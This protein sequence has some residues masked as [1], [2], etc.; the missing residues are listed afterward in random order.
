MYLADDHSRI[1]LKKG[2]TD[3]IN[4]SLIKVPESNR[5]YILSQVITELRPTSQ[6]VDLFTRVLKN[7]SSHVITELIVEQISWAIFQGGGLWS[8]T[9]VSIY[10]NVR[11]GL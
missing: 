8:T 5:R 10:Q 6:I 2:E 1:V 7:I 3:Y 4:A 9:F 11:I